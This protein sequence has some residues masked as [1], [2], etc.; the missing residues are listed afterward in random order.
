MDASLWIW[1]VVGVLA[2][3]A[4]VAHLNQRFNV[5]R[6]V[7]Q[8]L[9]GLPDRLR[10]LPLGKRTGSGR[11]SRLKISDL[12]NEE[13]LAME[14]EHARSQ[15]QTSEEILAREL[16]ETQRQHHKAP[17]GGPGPGDKTSE[18]IL[19]EELSRTKH[20]PGTGKGG[21][22]GSSER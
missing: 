8:G 13:L 18:D 16:A 1:N 5:A 17:A 9:G 19:R 10:N 3:I 7:R 14:M 12:T 2:G 11:K 6:I 20:D 4:L 21:T 15:D 22:K